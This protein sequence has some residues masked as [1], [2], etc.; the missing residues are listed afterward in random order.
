VEVRGAGQTNSTCLLVPNGKNHEMVESSCRIS[1]SQLWKGMCAGK[2]CLNFQFQFAIS[3]AIT[4]VIRLVIS[5]WVSFTQQEQLD[6]KHILL[7]C[8]IGLFLFYIQICL[9][10]L[11][12]YSFCIQW[13]LYFTFL[14][15]LYCS[16][17]SFL[18]CIDGVMVSVL[19][20]CAVKPKT[21]KLV[22]VA[23]PL[24]MQH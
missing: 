21:I 7:V 17:L 3:W 13:L 2:T 5:K 19:A 16:S 23:F 8:S 15:Y 24:S 18:N 22:F 11:D 20:S 9:V 6:A 4:L 14:M 10:S 12:W 1:L